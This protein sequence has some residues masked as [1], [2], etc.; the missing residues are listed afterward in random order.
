MHKIYMQ[1]D[2]EAPF[3]VGQKEE[4]EEFRM[5]LKKGVL[6][7]KSPHGQNFKIFTEDEI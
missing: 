6:Q 7:I 2:N 4:D 1:F 3:L 5:V